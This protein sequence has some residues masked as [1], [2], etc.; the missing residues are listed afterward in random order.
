[1]TK[2]SEVEVSKSSKCSAEE[3]S[4]YPKDKSA[5]TAFQGVL[6]ASGASAAMDFKRNLAS[7]T[8]SAAETIAGRFVMA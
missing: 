5:L 1:M 2:C 8:A 3:D 6:D 7:F 4:E